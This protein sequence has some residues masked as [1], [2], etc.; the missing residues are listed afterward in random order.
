MRHDF[1]PFAPWALLQAGGVM[2]VC[3]ALGGTPGQGWASEHGEAHSEPQN[4]K[5]SAPGSYGLVDWPDSPARRPRPRYGE[6]GG[7]SASRGMGLGGGMGGSSSSLGPVATLPS[8]PVGVT[9]EVFRATVAAGK[10]V[11]LPAPRGECNLSG[12]GVT[13]SLKGLDSCLAA[14]AAR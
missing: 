4:A 9:T 14:R 6:A 3:A 13:A 2:A 8:V 1:S 10:K 5:T 12:S 7:L 11:F